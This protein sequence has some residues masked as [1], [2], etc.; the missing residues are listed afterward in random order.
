MRQHWQKSQLIFSSLPALTASL[1]LFVLSC[2]SRPSATSV[3]SGLLSLDD[4]IEAA[5]EAIEGRVAN[6]SE[7]AVYKITAS[8]DAIG[9][10]LA[11]DLNDKI[12]MRGNL[13][14]L[15]RGAALRNVD[16][17]QQFQMSGMVS[18]ASAVGIGHYL[19]A[20]VVITGTFDRYADFSQLRIRAIDV[21]TSA[22][23][24]SYTARI[25]NGDRVL[26]NITAPLGTIQAPRITENALD[27]LNRGK[28]LF[29]EN[30]FDVAIAEFDKAIT[31]NRNLVEAYFY[32]GNAY[33]E[34]GDYDRAIVDYT[35]AIRL[36]PNKASA[37]YNRGVA[38]F[39]KGDYDRAIADYNQAIRLDPNYAWAYINRGNAYNRKSDYDRA[40]AD[41]N[42]AIR[43]DPD[44]ADAYINRGSA[45]GR[46]G[47]YDL[48]IA[49]YTQA[50][51]LNTNNADAYNYRGWTYALKGDYDQAITDAS[52][53][54]RIRPNDAN[55]LHTRGYAYLGKRD[56]DRAIADFEAALRIDPNLE[57]AKQ[58]LE[59]ARQA[60]GR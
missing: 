34:K 36:D 15:A 23:L 21:Q 35:Q 56:Y 9:D 2:A 16:A 46:K 17:E 24:Y 54:L 8:H 20:K 38:Y 33:S 45:Y 39:Y 59:K 5:A 52:T 19:G 42:Q 55:T 27:H 3:V 32:K 49:D 29:A 57:E 53:S 58:D 43:L 26:A 48:A 12:S 47:D 60:R 44:D 41:Y 30:K 1:V 4:A 10:Y 7:I 22:L 37:Y 11:E 18:D 14:P 40:I 13:I 25:H 28:D 50:I 31:I 51:R 6:G